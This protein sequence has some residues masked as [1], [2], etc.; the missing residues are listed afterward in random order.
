MNKEKG[1]ALI[2]IVVAILV[3]VAIAAGVYYFGKQ[4]SSQPRNT[5]IVS[6]SQKPSTP[7]STTTKD[8]FSDWKTYTNKKYGYSVRYPA[9]WLMTEGESTAVDI[10]KIHSFSLTKTDKTQNQVDLPGDFKDDAKYVISIRVSPNSSNYTAQEYILQNVS[11]ESQE[12][13]KKELQ[14]IIVGGGKGVKLLQAAAPASGLAT[15]IY[16]SHANKIYEFSYGAMAH[17][18][19]HTKFMNIFDQILSTF[20]FTD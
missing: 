8:E 12:E 18:E 14:D 3:L 15:T 19:T 13:F 9:D 6:E 5:P 11:P 1:Q 16:I 2:L 20:K 17:Q 7:S 4:N 10:P